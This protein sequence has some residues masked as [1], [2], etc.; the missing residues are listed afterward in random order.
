[1]AAPVRCTVAAG[2]TDRAAAERPLWTGLAGVVTNSVT[3][4]P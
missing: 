2:G 4:V 3:T 1:M